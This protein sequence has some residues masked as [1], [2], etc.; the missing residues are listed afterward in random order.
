MIRQDVEKF[1][2]E[3][4]PMKGT[5][6][7]GGGFKYESRPQQVEMALAVA[8]A[9]DDECNLCVEAPTGVGKTFAYLVPAVFRAKAEKKPVIVST[10]TINLQEQIITRDVPLLERMLDCEITAVVAKGKNNYLCLRRLDELDERG[11]E[12]IALDGASA[13]LNRLLRWA[14]R[15]KTGDRSEMPHGVSSLLWNTVCCERGNCPGGKCEHFNKCFMF[16]ARRKLF[17]A[18]IIISNHAKFFTSLAMSQ[19]AE[20]ENNKNDK[21]DNSNKDETGSTLPE[22]SAVILDEGHT[23]EECASNHLGLKADSANI[24]YL[25]G[26][27]YSSERQS[28]VLGGDYP[29]ATASVRYCRQCCDSFFA[30][31]I[32]W[33]APQ[34]H[35]PLRYRVPNHITNFLEGPFRQLH[36]KLLHVVLIESDEAR[37]AEISSLDEGLQEQIENM[38]SFFS[39]SLPGNVYWFE[40]EGREQQELSL[41]IVPIDV[42][43]VL[44]E[45]LFSKPPVIVTSATLAVNG[46]IGYFQKRVGCQDARSLILD[47]PFDYER[48]VS[49]HI[50]GHMPDPRDAFSFQ[51]EAEQQIRRFLIMTKGRAFVLFT[52]YSMMHKLAE[53][54]ESFFEEKKM[55]L[56]IQGEG[57]SPRKMLESFR[58]NPGSV[59]FGT[60]SF[61]TGVDVPGDALSNVIITRLP[62]SVPDHPLIEARTEKIAQEGRN[63]FFDYSVPEAVLKFRQGFGRLIRTREDT[64]IVVIL[65]NRVVTKCYGAS[66]LDSIPHCPREIF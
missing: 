57:L 12:F 15:T 30:S 34:K 58:S 43:P 4:S 7:E 52:S 47:T 16:R 22:Y 3:D 9:M 51:N 35:N 65:D 66:F 55:P 5:S 18:E 31:L 42:A 64:G 21:N 27:L 37:Q 11:Q 56:L 44:S 54:M 32:E 20:E 50:A 6:R 17:D 28:G 14:D 10:H 25:L 61:W 19:K 1:F 48:Q 39:M 8:S 26:R 63:A 60:A 24:R 41:N 46:D 2:G 53:R 23:L 36:D 29:E 33:L 13:E 59:I 40:R 45:L 62:F 49:L 38:T